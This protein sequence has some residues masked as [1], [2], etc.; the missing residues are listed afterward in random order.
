MKISYLQFKNRL[1]DT[2]YPVEQLSEELLAAADDSYY[3]HQWLFDLEKD[4]EQGMQIVLHV[5]QDDLGE[6]YLQDLILLYRNDKDAAERL[7]QL[8]YDERQMMRLVLLC[9]WN[10]ND[11]LAKK[12][13]H[14]FIVSPSELD[15]RTRFVTRIIDVCLDRQTPHVA[16]DAL[17]ILPSHGVE[18]IVFLLEKCFQTDNQNTANLILSYV[19]LDRALEI[20]MKEPNVSPN[21]ART[22]DWLLRD[23]PHHVWSAFVG[24]HP[25][26]SDHIYSQRRVL[27][28]SLKHEQPRDGEDGDSGRKK[29]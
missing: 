27:L 28:E 2:S 12:F 23:A 26:I 5:L 7:Y 29:I 10:R 4:N 13:L 21:P 9:C 16:E 20:L 1:P 14:Y 19:S 15:T 17:T 22:C 25:E 3:I 18:K 8:A 24:L 11:L 6:E